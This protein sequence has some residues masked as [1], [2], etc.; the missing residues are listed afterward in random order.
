MISDNDLYRLAIFLGSAAMVLIVLYHYV[1]VNAKEEE[2][3]EK[4][5]PTV[6][7][8]KAAA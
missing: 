6:K 5:A 8:A 2:Q 7:P 1:E 4:T 3:Q